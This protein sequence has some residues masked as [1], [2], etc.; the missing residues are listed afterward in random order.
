MELVP[1]ESFDLPSVETI[2]IS[3]IIC[4]NALCGWKRG[5]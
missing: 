1:G 4:A 5:S 3:G 2:V